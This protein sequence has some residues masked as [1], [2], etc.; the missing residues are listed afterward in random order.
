MIHGPCGVLNRKN[1]CMQDGNCRYHYP[2]PFSEAT[3]QGDDSYPIYRRRDDGRQV[4]IRGAV[5]D[6][7]WVVP[8]NPYLVMRYNCHINI[9]VCSSIKAVKY[10]FKYIHKGH[11]R[12]SFTLESV[13]DTVIDEIR[14]YRDARFISPPE[15][16]WRIFPFNLSEISPPVLQLQLHLANMQIVRYKNSD[17]L[18]NVIDAESSSRTMLTEYFR[19]NSID[20]YARN[21]LYKDFP[22]FYIWQR[23]HKTWRR[24]T[25]RIQIGRLVAAHP[26]EGER[27]YLRVLLNHVRGAT[28][29]R[30]LRT[31]EGAVYSTFREAAERR[32]LIEADNSI[33]DCLTEAATFQMPYALRR[34]F[35]TILAFCEVTHVR[36]LWDK[37]FEAM[38]DDFRMES[39]SN[40]AIRQRVLRDIGDLLYSM[41]KDIRIFDL[42]DLLDAHDY[43]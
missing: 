5:L 32:G 10:L 6:N 15:A 37:Q 3:L 41:G 11:D 7:R 19:M 13:G 27:Y 25:Q 1:S 12:A 35:A 31:V 28:S 22:E 20:S 39:M 21:F 24:R 14:Q 2:R 18:K 26:A 16:I 23:N 42:P 30:D 34:L 33:S 29:F 36:A 38:S 43:C 9:E 17:N 4:R 40:E 8:Y